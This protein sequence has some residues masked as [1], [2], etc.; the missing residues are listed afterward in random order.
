MIC[1]IFAYLLVATLILDNTFVSDVFES[2]AGFG[3]VK[4][5]GVI[6]SLSFNGIIFLIVTK[7][8]LFL[9]SVSIGV[10]F[11]IVGTILSALLSV[12]GYPLALYRNFHYIDI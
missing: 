5:P 9:I 12:I 4:M 11:G 2:V 7:I 8:I 3:F 10:L 6:F 1:G